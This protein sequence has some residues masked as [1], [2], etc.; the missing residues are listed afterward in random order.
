MKR[1][2]KTSLD[3]DVSISQYFAKGDIDV[4]NKLSDLADS[5]VISLEMYERITPAVVDATRDKVWGMLNS[6]SSVY[7]QF[8]TY[9]YFIDKYAR[10]MFGESFDKLSFADQSDV[11]FNSV[12]DTDGLF[13]AALESVLGV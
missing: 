11:V 3:G 6:P 10:Q 7:S 9:R 4:T 12:W 5:G 2:I 8:S 1:Y 13:V